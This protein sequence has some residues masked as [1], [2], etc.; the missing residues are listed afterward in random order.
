MLEL[1]L[2]QARLGWILG[3]PESWS[4]CSKA[5]MVFRAKGWHGESSLIKIG[6]MAEDI[7]EI[8]GDGRRLD[9]GW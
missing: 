6:S 9:L 4:D 7:G 2:G 8:K 1:L 5:I 3:V